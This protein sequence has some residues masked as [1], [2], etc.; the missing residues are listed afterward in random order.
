MR[1]AT[2]FPEIKSWLEELVI[3]IPVTVCKLRAAEIEKE[4]ALMLFEVIKLPIVLSDIVL[5][6]PAPACEIVMPVKL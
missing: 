6:F 4:K 3:V 5:M 1:L 2:V